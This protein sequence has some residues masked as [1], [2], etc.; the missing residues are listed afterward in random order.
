MAPIHQGI[1]IGR[2]CTLLA[3][4]AKKIKKKFSIERHTSEELD[5]LMEKITVF[6]A[7]I[8]EESNTWAEEGKAA[9]FISQTKSQLIE[10]LFRLAEL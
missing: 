1:K 4:V 5:E 7:Q 9:D 3:K 10:Q 8:E 2:Q 6:S